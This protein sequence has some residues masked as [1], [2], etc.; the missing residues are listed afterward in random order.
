MGAPSGEAGIYPGGGM[1]AV[2]LI[3]LREIYDIGISVF[4]RHP[5]FECKG[6]MHTSPVNMSDS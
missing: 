4:L 2:V 3:L 1:V 5:L 6:S